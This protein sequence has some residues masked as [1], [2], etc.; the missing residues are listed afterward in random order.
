M[1]KSSFFSKKKG[2]QAKEK[3]EVQTITGTDISYSLTR[4]KIK[5]LNLRVKPDGKVTVSAPL[6][7]PQKYIDTFMANRISFILS[8]LE[9]YDTPSFLSLENTKIKEG[10]VFYL[11]GNQCTV[12]VL[13]ATRNSV[14]VNH[15]FICIHSKVPDSDEYNMSLLNKFLV[16]Y[17]KK[18]YPTFLNEVFPKFENYSIPFPEIKVRQM[19]RRWGSCYYTQNSITLNSKLITKPPICIE[20]VIAHELSHF[21]EP[22]HSK[23]FYAVLGDIFPNWREYK[24][25]LNSHG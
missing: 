5:S 15:D 25:I 6:G 14:D 3:V 1:T 22:N 17:A 16:D 19:K 20:Y 7:L 11:L 9:K 12:K 2:E 13:P 23:A 18:L 8:A 21:V 4:K 24:K 10:D